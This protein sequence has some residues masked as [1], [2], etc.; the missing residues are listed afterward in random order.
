MESSEWGGEGE[1]YS[2]GGKENEHIQDDI[3]TIHGE[4]KA[5]WKRNKA[6]KNIALFLF[7]LAELKELDL[8]SWQII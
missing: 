1:V 3:K 2:S 6:K 7:Q 8:K 4:E 5:S